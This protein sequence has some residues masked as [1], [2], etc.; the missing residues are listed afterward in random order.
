M[1]NF[2]GH[3]VRN[4]VP[5]ASQSYSRQKAWQDPETQGFQELILLINVHLNLSMEDGQ[6][7]RNFN[8]FH[9]NADEVQLRIRL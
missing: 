1:Y 5:E 3:L 4:P 8:T 2:F 6:I 7:L 9:E